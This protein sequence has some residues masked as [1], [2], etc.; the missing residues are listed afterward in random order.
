MGSKKKKKKESYRKELKEVGTKERHRFRG[1]GGRFGSRNT[2]NG[3]VPTILLKDIEEVDTG[4]IVTD[5]LWFN[6]IK[7]FREVEPRE[8]DI[9]EFDA[10]VTRY[11]KGYY[12]HDRYGERTVNH[13]KADYHLSFPTN[14]VNVTKEEKRDIPAITIGVPN[15]RREKWEKKVMRRYLKEQQRKKESEGEK[16]EIL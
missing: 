16:I 14:I 9:L 7:A 1:R 13:T 8:G 15:K 12:E 4:K 11:V 10:R 6:S 5:H 2:R 3:P